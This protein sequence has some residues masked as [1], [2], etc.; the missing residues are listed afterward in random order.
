[1]NR[2]FGVYVHFPYCLAKCPYCD[3][4]SVASPRE[5]VPHRAYADAVLAELHRR[6][7]DVPGREVSTLFFGGGTPSLWDPR[8]LGRVVDAVRRTFPVAADL[9]ITAECNPSSLDE[10]RAR[11]LRDAGVNRV[12]IGV[13]SLDRSRLEFL[14]RLHDPDGALRA[15]RA[16]IDAGVPRVSADF[17]FGV[18]GQSAEDAVREM[19][20]IAD[21]GPTHVSAYALTIEPGTRFGALHQKRQLPLLPEDVV[22][23]SFVAL[24]EL[25][26]GRGYVHYEISNYGKP[27]EFARHNL[28]YWRGDDYLGL[29]CGAWGTVPLGA[30]HVR[31]RNTPVPDRYLG[32]AESWASADVFRAGPGELVSELETLSPEARL[33]ERLML[34]LRLAEGLDVEAAARDVGVDPWP[35][36]RVRAVERLAARGRIAREGPRLRIPYDAWLLADGTIA[37]VA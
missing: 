30:R 27:G 18:A 11:A 19:T 34:G 6:A 12:S 35:T 23:E 32:S 28:G 8:E 21:L 24:H 9:E 33:L 7:R 4:L 31:Y 10:A 37:E 16:A 25:L 26:T 36:E 14:G 2:P 13:Q 20:A 1:M 22:A 5:A 17:I 29:G 15:V 3:F